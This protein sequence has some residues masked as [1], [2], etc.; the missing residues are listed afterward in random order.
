MEAILRRGARGNRVVELKKALGAVLGPVAAEYAGLAM[1]DALD[2]DTEAA[3]R[4]WQAG[5]GLIADGVVGPRCLEALGVVAFA[6]LEATPS[7]DAVRTLFPATKP[8]NIARFLPYVLAAL[9]AAGLADR[10]LLLS[11]LG[12]IRAESEGFLPISEFQSQFNTPPGGAP[13]SLYDG[14]KNLGNTQAGDGARF[15]GRGFVQLTGRANYRQFGAELG[16]DLEAEPDLANAPEIAAALLAA[17]LTSRASALREALAADDLRRARKLVNGGSHGLARFKD[18]FARA[19]PSWPEAAATGLVGAAGRAGRQAPVGRAGRKLTAVPDPGDLRDRAYAPPPVSLPDQYPPD[20][21]IKACL[22]AYTR[23]GLIL[24]QG[25]EGACTGFGLACVINYLLWQKAGMP[26]RLESVSPR[27]LYDFARRYDEYAGEDYDGSSCRGALKGWHKHG[28]CLNKD[29]PYRQGESGTPLFGWAERA[30]RTTLGVYFRI[31]KASITD[32]QAAIREVGAVYVS[33]FTHDGWSLDKADR[34]PPAGHEDVP[35]IPFDGQPSRDGGHAF[36]LVGF[37]ERGFIV[38]NSWGVDW[39]RGGFAVLAYADWLANA[40]DAWVAALG[41]PGVV[42]GRLTGGGARA[43]AAA[44]ADQSRWWSEDQAYRHSVVLGNDGRVDRYLTE[45]EPSR[46][47]F[48][49]AC[50]LPDAWFRQSGA[51]SKRLVIYAHGGLNSESDGIDRARAMGRYFTGNGCYPLFLV[52]KTGILE[53]IGNLLR[54][55]FA[56]KPGLAGWSLADLSDPMIE[57]HLG[58]KAVRPIWSEMKENAQRSALTGRGGDL[59]ADALTKLAA[60]WGD[61]LEIY[62]VGHSAGSI[63][64]GAFLRLLA[65][66]GLVPRLAS[67]HL[68]AP[69]CSVEF[70]NQHYAALPEVMQKLHVHVLSNRVELDDNVAG[71]Y[72]KSLL[73]FVSNALETDLRTPILGLD[74]IN[75]P[76]YGGWDGASST[77]AALATWREVARAAG[78]GKRWKV[79]DSDKVLSAQKPETPIDAAH[80]SFD[81]DLAVIKSTLETITGGPLALAVDDLRG[82]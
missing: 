29:W 34:K 74:K 43:G 18:V 68:F 1:G 11:A 38:Q 62:L 80:G 71:I 15:M 23:A 27:M 52:W 77:V 72:R 78:L 14:R 37:N 13:F 46:K 2:A 55:A 9:R 66:R 45:D 7:A 20:E 10:G 16:I 49:Q 70:A 24:D 51:D 40:M 59:L 12:T 50:V 22:G 25:Q 26:K 75:D 48:H 8:A 21:R 41:V 47:L 53:S 44:G 76:G 67:T 28:V 61:Q 69:A 81:N 65:Q 57:K 60:T 79:I 82:F 30:T 19:A 5:V 3:L 31:D 17:F 32:L 64:L 58:R 73:Y 63:I 36:A 39:G 6:A 33:A 4:R 35:S 42:V 54:E 56:P